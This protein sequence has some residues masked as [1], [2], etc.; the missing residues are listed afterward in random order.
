MAGG[1]G[2]G[3]EG[4]LRPRAAAPTGEQGRGEQSE[5]HGAGDAADEQN[6]RQQ[7]AAEGGCRARRGELAQGHRRSRM[8]DDDAG[9]FK[10][11]EGEEQPDAGGDGGVERRGDGFDQAPAEAGEGEQQEGGARQEDRAEGGWP[12]HAH[13]LDDGV[14]E[15]SV[16]PHAGRHGERIAGD[17]PHEDTGQA[18]GQTGGRRDRGHGHPGGGEHRGVDEDDVGHRQ[19]RGAPG[20]DLRAPVGSQRGKVKVL[21]QSAQHERRAARSRAP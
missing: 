19:E 5:E 7:Q 3:G 11:D 15:V 18:G 6:R 1:G 4:R 8:R 9:V 2:D 20:E 12:R 16:Q 13:A 21:R 17:G 10:A 14:G